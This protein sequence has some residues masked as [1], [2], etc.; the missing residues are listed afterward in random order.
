[1][2]REGFQDGALKVFPTVFLHKI[3]IHIYSVYLSGSVNKFWKKIHLCVIPLL[4]L[5]NGH[6]KIPNVCDQMIFGRLTFP[7]TRW[8]VLAVRDPQVVRDQKN[9]G[10]HWV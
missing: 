3:Y 4:V 7:G 1:M 8:Y 10:N 6:Y 2:V 9:F 5:K